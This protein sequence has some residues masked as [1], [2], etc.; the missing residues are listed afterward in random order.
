MVKQA[1][2]NTNVSAGSIRGRKRAARMHMHFMLRTAPDEVPRRAIHFWEV[3][4]FMLAVHREHSSYFALL[5]LAQLDMCRQVVEFFDMVE[6]Y[7]NNIFRRDPAPGEAHGGINDQHPAIFIY[8]L[9]VR[10]YPWLAAPKLEGP[11]PAEGSERDTFGTHE[12]RARQL[13]PRPWH[14]RGR[15]I[16]SFVGYIVARGADD[17]ATRSL[18]RAGGSPILLR[19]S[20]FAFTYHAGDG[21]HEGAGYAPGK[22]WAAYRPR[23][24]TQ[25][26]LDAVWARPH[27]AAEG[28]APAAPEAEGGDGEPALSCMA[29]AFLAAHVHPAF[30]VWMLQR[31]YSFLTCNDEDEEGGTRP[32]KCACCGDAPDFVFIP[33]D[34][35]GHVFC[36]PCFWINFCAVPDPVKAAFTCPYSGVDLDAA[37]PAAAAGNFF[38]AQQ[39]LSE[40]AATDAERAVWDWGD[41]AYAGERKR[42]AKARYD[43]LPKPKPR[44]RPSENKFFDLGPQGC[45]KTK[46][47]EELSSQPEG[48][49]CTAK[50]K[51]NRGKR[52]REKKEAAAAAAAA[53]PDASTDT[54][55]APPSKG[56]NPCIDHQEKLVPEDT[57]ST[58]QPLPQIETPAAA[59]QDK[60]LDLFSDR[61]VVVATAKDPRQAAKAERKKMMQANGGRMPLRK[62]AA[63]KNNKEE[64]AFRSLPLL[65]TKRLSP[66]LE[67]DGR[68][69]E[70]A[71]ACI[72]G[73]IL[74]ATALAELGVDV[75]APC[76]EYRQTPL[77]LACYSGKVEM[78]AFLVGALG[79]DPTLASNGGLSTCLS[80]AAANGEWGI[81]EYLRSV[82]SQI[83]EGDTALYRAPVTQLTAGVPEEQR[84]LDADGECVSQRWMV[85]NLEALF[86][87]REALGSPG[88]VEHRDPANLGVVESL[89]DVGEDH[90]GNGSYVIDGAVPRSMLGWLGEVFDRQATAEVL[91]KPGT[92]ERRYYCDSEGVVGCLLRDVIVR[93]LGGIADLSQMS[94]GAAPRAAPVTLKE[95]LVYPHMRFLNYNEVG[96]KVAPHTD[97]ARTTADG[98]HRSS[99][100]F[101]LYLSDVASTSI[102]RAKEH[103]DD[104]PTAI[105]IPPELLAQGGPGGETWLL[106]DMP[107]PRNGFAP[108]P[109]RRVEPREGRL[110]LF[111]H[112][113]P[114]EGRLVVRPPKV[115]LRG[116]V[117]LLFSNYRYRQGDTGTQ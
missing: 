97:L 99:H 16:W 20:V 68:M 100:T 49:G 7:R 111:P 87:G 10:H 4:A 54:T 114:H 32:Y 41:P 105:P 63:A 6:Y 72:S 29:R 88:K 86:E 104:S 90:A 73:D 2:V 31:L 56:H 57:E 39:T 15:G 103:S 61:S 35:P 110:L 77:F 18:L 69:N 52:H 62:D 59:S 109:R 107:N 117:K 13:V 24:L 60:P 42:L 75:D 43:A 93:H 85:G 22:H 26:M 1:A 46:R 21:G 76:N 9:M 116:E 23:P 3:E 53:T 112:D 96:G 12:R 115:L 67:Q 78:V 28:P 14:A 51:K 38:K 94:P 37:S 102:T 80:V 36:E 65:A 113:C 66:G 17:G 108:A 50:K 19:E 81:V 34:P 98:V 25:A 44:E 55:A 71:T 74:R 70:F 64:T 101:I 58:V 8:R 106:E 84:L 33:K 83:H 5:Y 27:R 48:D 47:S 82:P 40:S 95:C 89:I 79:A 92:A 11:P 30:A 45:A 91:P